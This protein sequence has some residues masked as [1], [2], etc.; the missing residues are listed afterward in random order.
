MR[1]REFVGE[2]ILTFLEFVCL[3]LG[4]SREYKDRVKRESSLVVERPSF[5]PDKRGF[6]SPLSRNK[7][8]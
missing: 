3:G 8:E 5:A 2:Y 6:D 4:D 1:F 7:G